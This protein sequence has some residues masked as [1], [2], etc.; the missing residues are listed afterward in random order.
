MR[1]QYSPAQWLCVIFL[2]G[3]YWM[4]WTEI[5]PFSLLREIRNM[6]DYGIAYSIFDV[7]SDL[8]FP[9]WMISWLIK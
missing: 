5:G 2:G 9:Y 8:G 3:F 6:L 7:L 1:V 4:K